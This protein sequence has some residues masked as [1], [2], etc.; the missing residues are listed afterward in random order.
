MSVSTTGPVTLRR[1]FLAT[2][3]LAIGTVLWFLLDDSDGLVAEEKLLPTAPVKAPADEVLAHVGGVAI[4]RQRVEADI[5]PRLDEL[6][7]EARRL[8]AEALEARI[9]EQL[10]ITAAETRGVDLETLLELEVEARL[11][12]VADA[13]VEAL[14]RALG[15]TATEPRAEIET[16]LRRELRRQAL[17]EELRRRSAI[18]V[19]EIRP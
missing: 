13:E 17:I 10:L 12:E 18:A 3:S 2:A 14:Y 1:L 6:A 11:D 8:R 15:A 7:E 9:A 5:A 4:T 16:R 19:Y